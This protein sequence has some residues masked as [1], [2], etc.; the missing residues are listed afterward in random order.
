VNTP[1]EQSVGIGVALLCGVVLGSA[2]AVSRF[3]YDA[4]ASAVVV[5]LGRSVVMITMLLIGLA[6]TRQSLHL[7]RELRPLV[8]VNG[9]L[10]GVMTYGNIGAVEFIPVGLAALL[11]FTFPIVIAVLVIAL[12]IEHVTVAKL[13]AILV[14]FT[15]LALML[16]V[17]VGE[18]DGRGTALAL[19]GS[20]ATAVNAI[21]VGRY[22]RSVNV[23][24]VTLH[25]SIVTLVF[26]VMLAL[27]VVPVRLPET[28]TGWGGLLGVALFQA[29]GTPLYFYAIAK[30][31]ALKT[32]MAINIQPVTSIVEAWILFD[33][34]LA[35][36]QALGGG[37]VLIAIGFMQWI[38]LRRKSDPG[39]D[40]TAA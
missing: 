35:A 13:G 11:F 1:D 15:G 40:E 2:V 6:L 21:L 27:F 8:V 10:M 33:E 32:A 37:L 14:A 3:A 12:R 24:V 23:F 39:S 18:V 17:S 20:F 9:V 36:L 28:G 30:V 19:M 16:G 25:F 29:V 34:V 22:F 31:G 38:D 7:P 5:A 26:L 4:G